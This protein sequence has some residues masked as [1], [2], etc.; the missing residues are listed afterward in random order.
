MFKTFGILTPFAGKYMFK[1]NWI[2]IDTRIKST[3]AGCFMFI[4]CTVCIANHF[5]IMNESE[6]QMKVGWLEL[7]VMA[8]FH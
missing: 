2:F 1:I 3:N 5:H 4:T 8:A 7:R 6:E